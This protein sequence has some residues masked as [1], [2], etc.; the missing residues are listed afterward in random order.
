[1][2]CDWS[3][4]Q[5]YEKVD[6]E[7][8][9][10][11]H[12][13]Q[14][15]GSRIT[16]NEIYEAIYDGKHPIDLKY[17]FITIKGQGGK[18]SSSLGNVITLKD[19]LEVYEPEIIRHLFASTRPN[20]EFAISFDLDVIKVYEDYDKTE[21]IYF[22]EQLIENKKKYLKELR[23]YELSQIDKTPEKLPL[24]V[25]FRHLTNLVQIHEGDIAKVVEEYKTFIKTDF[26]KKKLKARAL[27][28]WN[29]INKYA[30]EDMKFKIHEKISK[31]IKE[32]LTPEQKKAIKLLVKSLN[33][34]KYDEGSLFEEFYNIC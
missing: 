10:K 21:R 17:D 34:K 18:M 24:Q 13:A 16:A 29:W 7:L 1:W 5:H 19:C 27:C 25:P 9:G 31:A 20:T 2:R 8:A 26:D 30:P 23:I 3:A 22:D 32:K 11:E 28:A 33:K 4:R 12:Y 14:P 6:F 15:G